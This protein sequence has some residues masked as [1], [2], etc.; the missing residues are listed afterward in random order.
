M[1]DQPTNPK[2]E[3]LYV[4]PKE[5]PP[6]RDPPPNTVGVA[7]WL[8]ENLFSNIVNSIM[9]VLVGLFVVWFL[10]GVLEWAVT[11]AGWTVVNNNLRLLMVGQYTR[12][13]L[14]RVVALAVGLTVLSGVS[15]GYWS[16]V[17]R[18]VF[19]TIIGTLA[20]FVFIPLVSQVFSPPAIRSIVATEYVVPPMRFIGDQ[21]QQVTVQ[22]EQITEGDINAEAANGFIEAVP[23][24][25]NSRTVWNDLKQDVALDELD[26]GEYNL[27][28]PCRLLILTATR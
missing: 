12:E 1:T 20:V 11:S 19:A 4:A 10:Y 28:L 21:G 13:E 17:P 6:P 24:E 7:G 14:W 9:T 18:P 26:M 27:A 3:L 8:R 2:S 23:G 16:D 15:I 22:V 5:A 25:Q